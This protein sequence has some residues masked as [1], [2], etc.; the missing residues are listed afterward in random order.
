MDFDLVGSE[1]KHPNRF[2][3]EFSGGHRRRIGIARSLTTQSSLLVLDEPR[4][5]KKSQ[6]PA[7]GLCIACHGLGQGAER[8]H[9]ELRLLL[10]R[11]Y[12][13]GNWL[14]LIFLTI[15]QMKLASGLI[16]TPRSTQGVAQRQR[17]RSCAANAT[18]LRPTLCSDAGTTV[19]PEASLNSV[20]GMAAISARV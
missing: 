13:Y 15:R 9:R 17:L 19:R 1:P 5:G 18:Q 8:V 14:G 10:K 12:F 3:H 7:H 2:P 4:M 16:G 11:Q 6:T 20:G